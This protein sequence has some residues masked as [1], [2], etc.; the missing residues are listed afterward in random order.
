MTMHQHPVVRSIALF[1]FASPLI[2][3]VAAYAATA[4]DSV[5]GA[6]SATSFQTKHARFESAKF[7]A[8]P[9]WQDD[10]LSDAW[11][12]FRQSC[13]ALRKKAA[14]RS[15]CDRSATLE[16]GNEAALRQFFEQEFDL[17]QIH[18]VDGVPAGVITG[19]YEPQLSGSR[20]S[21]PATP[22]PVYAIPDD[23]LFLEARLVPA[24]VGAA[25]TVRVDGRNVLPAGPIESHG[26]TYQLDLSGIEPDIRNRKYR[27][28]MD[29]E[30]VVP[31]LSRQEIERAPLPHA[32]VIAWVDNRAALYSMQIQGS[33]KIRL[34]NGEMIRVGY[35][36][37]NGHAFQPSVLASAQYVDGKRVSNRI[38]TRSLGTLNDIAEG[39]NVVS[40]AELMA[41][42][43]E[44]THETAASDD[45]PLTRGLGR[46]PRPGAS[47]SE[48]EHMIEMLM[49]S[50]KGKVADAALSATPDRPHSVAAAVLPHSVSHAATPPVITD[51]SETVS[52][53]A[54]LTLVPAAPRLTQGKQSPSTS[55][56]ISA[57]APG[58]TGQASA[59]ADP[60]KQLAHRHSARLK[61]GP[62]AGALTRPL[63][64]VVNGDPSY[65]FFR[66]IPNTGD[67]PIGA[68][69]IPLTAGRSLAVDPRTTP[70]GFPVFISTRD[71]ARGHVLN[72][73]MLAQDTGGAIR[74]AV[75]AD[76][77]WGFGERAFVQASRMK[78]DGKMWLL[79]PK[80][81]SRPS[82][83]DGPR[84]RG[85]APPTM[86]L[87]ECVVADV[88][89]C[90]E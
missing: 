74:G 68:L 18:N 87:S 48:V 73:L 27:L 21:G 54:D 34:P 56:T 16:S 40:K 24:N 77:F 23:M 5:G 44:L 7:D 37:Q 63:Q 9:G 71:P 39:Q 30:R 81:Q 1:T 45:A 67:G 3:A 14:W 84:V 78:E 22:Y 26:K 50:G 41:A 43:D 33:G 64:T 51:R 86:A 10:R 52:V 65:V 89:F 72:R 4:D 32:K 31:Y 36:E 11:S 53:L 66:E 90:T 35:A 42:F 20:Q 19:Y 46:T 38:L 80:A 2:I 60:S 47:P 62:D 70:L 75:R 85:I 76:Y 69:G 12:A 6:Y 8:L 82:N 88:D 57:T 49:Q 55:D 29:G 61:S 25:L 59:L 28:R 58:S 79:L 83:A 17:F 13:S 15:T